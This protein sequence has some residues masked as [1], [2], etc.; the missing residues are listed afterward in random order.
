MDA[1]DTIAVVSAVTAWEIANKVRLAKW[2]EVVELAA[3]FPDVLSTHGFESISVSVEHARLAGSLPGRHRDPFD[4]MLAAQSQI[5]QM[6]LVTADPV[7][8]QFGTQVMW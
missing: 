5:E 2:P 7:F 4:R 8:A 6:P 1:D 3:N